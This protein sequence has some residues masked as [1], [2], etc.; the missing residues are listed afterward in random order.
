MTCP[1]FECFRSG[2]GEFLARPEY[3]EA[4]DRAFNSDIRRFD[5]LERHQTFTERGSASWDAFMAG[6]W[7]GALRLIEARRAQEEQAHRAMVDRGLVFRRLRVAELPISPYLQWEMHS[8]R[9]RS[10][11]GAA[12]RVLDARHVSGLEEAGRLPEMVILGDA[13]MFGVIYDEEL[14]GA[15]ARRFTD[16]GEIAATIAE[17]E[18]LYSKAEEFPAFFER[19]IAPLGPPSVR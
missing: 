6:D 15:G 16:P 4:Y 1:V 9:Q 2:A 12:I 18:S 11:L 14:K 3:F 13:V 5:K 7:S 10:E 19:E 17:F 8:F